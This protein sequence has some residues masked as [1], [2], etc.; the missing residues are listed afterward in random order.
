MHDEG[1]NP[2]VL[3]NPYPQAGCN[4]TFY[5]HESVFLYGNYKLTIF[6]STIQATGIQTM[7][8]LPGEEKNQVWAGPLPAAK[9]N[10]TA[11]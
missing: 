9:L 7:Q 11:K 2:C 4:E 3:F 10:L 6:Y 1:L 5:A 8:A